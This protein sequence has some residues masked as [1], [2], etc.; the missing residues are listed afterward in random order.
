MRKRNITLSSA[1]LIAGL[2]IFLVAACMGPQKKQVDISETPV[3]TAVD[4]RGFDPLELPADNE[5]ISQTHPRTGEIRGKTLLVDS[6]TSAAAEKSAQITNLPD[7]VDTLNS[8]AYRIQVFTSK[9]YGEARQAVRIAE[10]IFDR[11]VYID[12]EVPNF[13]VRVGSFANR[14][15]AEDYLP[16]VRAAGYST[17]W[18][19]MVNVAVKQAAPLYEDEY[20]YQFEDTTYY[21]TTYYDE[22]YGTDDQ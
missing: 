13:K 18:V 10:E 6:D 14:E 15:D 5:I 22:G 21:D 8:Q 20:P 7:Q 9:L 3:E 19:V 16:R 2:L 17:G 1:G 4:S 12:Y 11:P